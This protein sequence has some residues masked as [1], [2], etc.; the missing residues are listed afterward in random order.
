MVEVIAYIYEINRLSGAV[1]KTCLKEHHIKHMA[2]LE[3]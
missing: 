3:V 2:E 1:K